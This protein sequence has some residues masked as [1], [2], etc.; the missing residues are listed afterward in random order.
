MHMHESRDGE[1]VLSLVIMISN[2][3]TE[4]LLTHQPYIQLAKLLKKVQL[5]LDSGAVTLLK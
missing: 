4:V 5:D 2:A 1:F 3:E